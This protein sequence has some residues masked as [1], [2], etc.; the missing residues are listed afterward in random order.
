MYQNRGVFFLLPAV[1]SS[2]LPSLD[3]LRSLAVNRNAGELSNLL[4]ADSKELLPF[5]CIKTGGCYGAGLKYP[6]HVDPVSAPDHSQRQFLVFW[7]PLTSEDIGALWFEVKGTQLHYIPEDQNLGARIL[8]NSIQSRFD[9]GQHKASF[10]A[11]TSIVRTTAGLTAIRVGPEFTFTSVNANGKQVLFDQAGGILLFSL[12]AGK[13]TLNLSYSGIMNTP[14][15]AGN[16]AKSGILLSDDYWYPMIARNP[17]AYSISALIPS[18]WKAIGQGNL[19]S[20]KPEGDLTRWT[21]DMPLPISICSFSAGPFKEVSQ[22]VNG[23][24]YHVWSL[25]NSV[26]IMKKELQ[27]YPPVIEYYS[28]VFAKF[29]FS[30]YGPVIQPVIGD[31]ALEAYSYA[32]YPSLP[33]QDPHEPSH[34]WWGGLI[35]NTYLHSL[36]NE[37]FADFSVANFMQHCAIG[38]ES[39]RE[40]AF[41][42]HPDVTT[43]DGPIADGTTVPIAA[44]GAF[45]G[46]IASYL[47]YNKGAYVLLQLER[48]LGYQKMM[49]CCQRW[50][51]DHPSDQAGEWSGFEKAVEAQEGPSWKWFFDQWIDKAGVPDFTF[52]NVH[53]ENGNL[54]FQVKFKGRPYRM[55]ANTMLFNG[56]KSQMESFEIQGQSPTEDYSLPIPSGFDRVS[57]D[58]YRELIHRSIGGDPRTTLNRST[59]TFEKERFGQTA[60]VFQEGDS[61]DALPADFANKAVYVGLDKAND[62]G[63]IAAF[64]SAGIHINGDT[65]SWNGTTI[66]LKDGCAL[67]MVKFSDGVGVIILGNPSFSPE[68]GDAS[69]ALTDGLGR[70]LRGKTSFVRSGPWTFSIQK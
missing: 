50:I 53:A 6:W 44:G 67:A 62:P 58:P 63:V 43:S 20:V 39:E 49:A 1:F 9:L 38:N 46:P 23:I 51:H 17:V 11:E 22:K 30:S 16:V 65:A 64:Q 41:A 70:F 27:F 66:N 37:S 8:H 34:T 25:V 59:R 52:Q 60:A 35:P 33:G 47:G 19:V 61:I 2:K 14:Y 26:E 68:T 13:S 28:S 24:E 48:E 7:S 15:Y 12:P 36:W 55:R 31:S 40:I 18:A 29:P 4:D 42:D 56:E 21:Y 10:Q 57:F 54:K 5:D 45:R 32:T 3:H 69:L